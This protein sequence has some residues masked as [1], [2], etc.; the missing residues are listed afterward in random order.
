MDLGGDSFPG[1]SCWARVPV[2]QLDRV[3]KAGWRRKEGLA[4]V[5]FVSFLQFH[6]IVGLWILAAM[7]LLWLLSLILKDSSIVDIFWGFGF[8]VSAW[9]VY[10]ITS[11]P[12]GLRDVL[13]LALV[14]IWGLRL[15]LHV[16]LRNAGKGEDFRYARWREE[17]GG[18]WWWHSLFK[19]NLLQG[20]ILWIV[21]APLTAAQLPAF[22]GPLNLLDYLGAGL[23]AFGFF[24]EA[25]GDLQL[26]KFRSDPENKGKVLQRG[27]WR[28]TRHPNYF[29]DAAQWWGFFLIAAGAGA[30]WTIV[31]PIL[32]T[33]LLVRVSGMDL[34]EKTLKE[35]P[36]YQAYIEHT[37]AFIPWFPKIVETRK[38]GD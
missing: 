10:F 22:S 20:L 21:A 36:G 31:S 30:W 14:T 24:F 1:R 17:S 33:Y 5:V 26:K 28:L 35:K 13:L 27:V 12:I 37:S 25:V 19:V 7:L 2:L 15:S 8:V 29:G 9:I 32:M 3:A 6:S 18:H 34:L 38:E 23:W 11:G 16:F 4:E